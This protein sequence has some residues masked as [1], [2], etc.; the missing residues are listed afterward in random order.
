MKLAEA[1][2]VRGDLQ[3]KLNQMLERIRANAVVQQGDKPSEAPEKLLRQA[4][5][6]QEELR[7]LV[8]R[9]NRSNITAK[10]A[11]GRT[12]ME[13]IAERDRLKQQH[14]FLTS[15]ASATKREPD[16]YGMREIKWVAQ[17]PVAK[18]QKQAD[19]ASK[20]LRELN[21]RIQEANW[22]NELEP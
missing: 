14:A 22:K 6:M 5:G 20:E 10:I 21:M 2:I 11:D 9:I 3:T 17:L 18:L 8:V 16:R 13:A 12:M 19:D 15:A 7:D 1:L 4:F